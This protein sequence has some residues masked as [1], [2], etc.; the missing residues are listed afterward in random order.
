M[1]GGEHLGPLKLHGGKGK[2]ELFGGKGHDKVDGG[3]DDDLIGGG[4]GHDLLLGGKGKDTFNMEADD[5]WGGRYA[6]K[7]AGDGDLDGIGIGTGQ[8]IKLAGKNK[9]EDVSDGGADADILRLTDTSDAFFLHDSFSGFYEEVTTVTD[10]MGNQSAKRVIGI[11]TIEAGGG[12]DIVDLTSETFRIDE[13]LGMEVRGGDGNDVIWASVGDDTLDGGN[14][15]DILFGGRGDDVLTGGSGADTFQFTASSGH[16]RITDFGDGDKIQIFARDGVDAQS[17]TVGDTINHTVTVQNVGGK[18]VYFIDG[19]QQPDLNLQTGNTYVFDVSA[20]NAG[21][22]FK[23]ST[24]AD[25]VHGQGVEFTDGV[26]LD[27][28]LLTIIVGDTTPNL[29]YYCDLHPGMGGLT[30]TIQKTTI[31]WEDVR[32]TLE[33]DTHFDINQDV[34]FSAINMA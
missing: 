23:F 6:A 15:D 2:D 3:D 10:G 7:N 24:T 32:I 1:L 28:G 21:H 8:K 25:G 14:D 31:A 16:D 34:E 4:K 5:V 33:D 30:N 11:E 20:I 29:E 27:N 19:E 22:P 12:D 13:V 18:N 9:F 17:V 26:T